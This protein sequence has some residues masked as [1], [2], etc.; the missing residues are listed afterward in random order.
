MPNINSTSVL[1]YVVCLQYPMPKLK[2]AFLGFVFI[3]WTT[4]EFSIVLDFHA[5]LFQH[6]KQLNRFLKMMLLVVR[7]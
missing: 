7:D 6:F 4:E 3:L 2:A 5:E 1:T